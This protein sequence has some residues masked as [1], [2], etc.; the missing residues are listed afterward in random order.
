MQLDVDVSPPSIINIKVDSYIIF[1]S[2]FMING[3]SCI[4][5]LNKSQKNRLNGQ[6]RGDAGQ[7]A[8]PGGNSRHTACKTPQKVV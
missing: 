1:S 7:N 6:L 5:C 3:G 8:P 4:K 2:A